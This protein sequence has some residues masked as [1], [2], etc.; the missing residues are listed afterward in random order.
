MVYKSQRAFVHKMIE[1]Y[2]VDQI[3]D[4]NMHLTNGYCE[5]IEENLFGLT[6]GIAEVFIDASKLDVDFLATT[7]MAGMLPLISLFDFY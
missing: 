5:S 7:N 1:D 2:N 6:T 3:S 4:E